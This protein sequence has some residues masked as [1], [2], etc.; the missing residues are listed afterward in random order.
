MEKRVVGSGV[1]GRKE[2]GK[3]GTEGMEKTRG[4]GGEV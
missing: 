2:E 1:Q 4:R 3:V